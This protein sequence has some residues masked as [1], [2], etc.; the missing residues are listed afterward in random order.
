MEII[1]VNLTEQEQGPL[2]KL[3]GQIKQNS[4][5]VKQGYLPGARFEKIATNTGEGG[6]YISSKTTSLWISRVFGYV[7]TFQQNISEL[8][9]RICYQGRY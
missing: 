4:F 7:G 3:F 2:L 6:V 8:F 1:F 9:G 5:S